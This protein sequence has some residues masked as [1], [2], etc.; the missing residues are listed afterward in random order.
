L[1]AGAIGLTIGGLGEAAGA[2]AA[3][4]AGAAGAAGRAGAA[5]PAEA[6][7]ALG[8]AGVAG[9]AAFFTERIA[10][11]GSAVVLAGAGVAGR[12][13]GLP[14]PVISPRMREASSSL[15]ELLWLLTAMDSFSAASST[16]LFSRPKSR[17]SS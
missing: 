8:A 1:A 17:D 16:S 15:I 12:T 14:L 4:R 9:A 6:E 7:G 13:A 10:L 11:G 2:A 5:G 3:G